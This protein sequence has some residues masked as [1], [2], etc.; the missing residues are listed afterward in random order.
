MP[1]SATTDTASLIPGAT[2]RVIDQAGHFPWIE[3]R[4][5]VRQ[6]IEDFLGSLEA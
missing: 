2:V 1:M 4:G 6:V 3:R 5:V